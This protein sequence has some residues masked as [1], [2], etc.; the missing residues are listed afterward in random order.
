MEYYKKEI[1]SL[2][3]IFSNKPNNLINNSDEKDIIGHRVK[4]NIISFQL[5]AIGRNRIACHFEI[6]EGIK[7][8]NGDKFDGS[9][10]Y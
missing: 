4:K 7:S 5:L 2:L 1:I 8:I 10:L 6:E 9:F 3:N